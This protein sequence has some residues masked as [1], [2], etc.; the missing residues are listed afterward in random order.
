M[1]FHPRQ[2]A[3]ICHSLPG[4]EIYEND[5]ICQGHRRS[6]YDLGIGDYYGNPFLERH[7][8][9]PRPQRWPGQER[10]QE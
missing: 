6:S 9:P 8:P 4:G 2:A 3:L 7:P 1:I 10:T 5:R